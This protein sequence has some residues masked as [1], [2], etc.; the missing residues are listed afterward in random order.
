DIVGDVMTM[1]TDPNDNRATF[2]R[3]FAERLA[4]IGTEATDFLR[5][6]L[7]YRDQGDG[8]IESDGQDSVAILQVCVSLAV[9]HIRAKAPN[10]G[11]DRLAVVRRQADF[12][13]QRPQPE[14]PFQHAV[15]GRLRPRNGP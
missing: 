15:V 4:G 8:A 3:V 12:A 5:V 10:T 7:L 6:R 13:R 14:R 1:A 11:K 9:L 2:V